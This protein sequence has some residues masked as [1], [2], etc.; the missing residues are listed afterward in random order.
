MAL[1]DK[2]RDIVR[3]SGRNHPLIVQLREG[4]WPRGGVARYTS[5]GIP[6]DLLESLGEDI[7]SLTDWDA[8][9]TTA[10]KRYRAW[11]EKAEHEGDPTLAS[12][13]FLVS[14]A[15]AF[16]AQLLPVA[17]SK[18]KAELLHMCRSAYR[19]AAP[20]LG[21]PAEYTELPFGKSCITAYLR[22]AD[23]PRGTVIVLN[24]HLTCKE[25]LHYFTPPLL[26]LGL[27][28]VCIDT[29]GTGAC[30]PGT[31]YRGSTGIWEPIQAHLARTP[32]AAH[33]PVLVLALGVNGALA[34]QLAAA[35]PDAFRAVA[36]L[37][38]PYDLAAVA[39]RLLPWVVDELL[40]YFECSREQLDEALRHVS[41]KGAAQKTRVPVL[42]A[43]GGK[44]DD[45]PKK[46]GKRLA[47]EFGDTG[48]TYWASG[49]SGHCAY[50]RF[51][52]LRT[53]VCQWLGR[54]VG[55]KSRRRAFESDS[56]EG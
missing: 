14:S 53:R 48:A 27:N 43:A 40:A 20:L 41:T 12:R 10:S 55:A 21:P 19:K 6:R 28:T 34:L 39:P 17:G 16:H 44:D 11:G 54:Q 56:S 29:P 1:S 52:L 51:P 23:R 49:S 9:W 25:D 5:H 42:I 36:L 13:Y 33:V 31:P 4:E 15:C 30:I 26:E 45:F 7:N 22:T 37:S 35:Y 32:G 47:D 50:E 3:T 38:P 8:A 46:Q 24:S 18:R 2:L